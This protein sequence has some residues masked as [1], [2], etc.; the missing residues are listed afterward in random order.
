[1]EECETKYKYKPVSH[2]QTVKIVGKGI[3]VDI[4]KTVMDNGFDDYNVPYE[5][6]SLVD[7]NLSESSEPISITVTNEFVITSGKGGEKDK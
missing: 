1:M 7:E 2:R 5:C 6:Q 3:A 4:T